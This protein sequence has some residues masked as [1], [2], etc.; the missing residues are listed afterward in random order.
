MVYATHKDSQTPWIFGAY[1]SLEEAYNVQEEMQKNKNYDHLTW[2]NS[3]V[4]LK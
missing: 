1:N 3:I 4:E 2:S